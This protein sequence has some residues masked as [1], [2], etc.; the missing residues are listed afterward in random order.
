MNNGTVI[1]NVMPDYYPD[2]TD[3][4]W[5]HIK[6]FGVTMVSTYDCRTKE[7]THWTGEALE[8]CLID[9]LKSKDLIISF[10]WSAFDSIILS[11]YGDVSEI[12][13]FCLMSQVQKDVGKRLK[14]Q[15]LGNANGIDSTRQ[16]L[17]QF[18]SQKPDMGCNPWLHLNKINTIVR[19]MKRAIDK[20][21]L[22]HYQAS[23]DDRSPRRF[24]TSHWAKLINQKTRRF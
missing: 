5:S 6:E 18:L 24:V 22:W 2:A 13:A 1:L 10:N 11:A 17:V 15:N 14:L 8:H 16:G 4:N 20:Q 12:P 7:T 23:A 19:L 21:T 3:T 9:Y